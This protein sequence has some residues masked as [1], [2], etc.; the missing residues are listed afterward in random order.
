M[1]DFNLVGSY[2]CDIVRRYIFSS[3]SHMKDSYD[4]QK[5]IIQVRAILYVDLN[6]GLFKA[7]KARGGTAFLITI[8]IL[9]FKFIRINN[10]IGLQPSAKRSPDNRNIC[11]CRS[12]M[13]EL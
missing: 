9:T 10:I 11:S 6:T 1:I 13:V 2:A 12:L 3:L 7:T 5:H 8:D 4:P